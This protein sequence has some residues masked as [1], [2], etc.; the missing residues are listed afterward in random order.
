MNNPEENHTYTEF[1]IKPGTVFGLMLLALGVGIAF[2][3][4]SE[5]WN[6]YQTG[7]NSFIKIIIKNLSLDNILFIA[8]N[9]PIQIG[10]T[11]KYIIAN[12]IFLSLGSF[13]VNIGTSFI[14]TGIS[15]LYPEIKRFQAQM[16]GL[17]KRLLSLE[18]KQKSDHHR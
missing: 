8:P 9:Q 3:V 12:I 6:F 13:A 5:G 2:T 18:Q 11:G 1:D 7:N 4:L 15:I 10:N 16:T 14:K 17:D